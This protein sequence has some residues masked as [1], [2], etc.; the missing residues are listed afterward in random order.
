MAKRI[1]NVSNRAFY[2][3][4]P[5]WQDAT[6]DDKKQTQVVKVKLYSPAYFALTRRNAQLAKW[7]SVGD[8]VLIAANATQAVQFSADGKENL[9]DKE[10]DALA[11]P[12]QK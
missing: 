12:A 8:N 11:G 1:K 6:F 5:V 3:V 10:V 2:Q 9:T 7:A 4:G